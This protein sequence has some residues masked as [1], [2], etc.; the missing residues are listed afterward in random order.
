VE[1]E[2]FNSMMGVQKENTADV[3]G[4]QNIGYQ[5]TGDWMDYIVTLPNT[6][7]YTVNFRVATMNTGPQFQLRKP[8]GTVLATINVPNTGGWQNWQTVSAQVALTQGTQHLQIFTSN[9]A[10]GWNINWME[11]I[12]GSGTPANQPPTASAGTAQTIT[13]PV[14]TVQLTG[15]GS[16]AEGLVTFSW[17][18]VS[19][20]STAT[21]G[22]AT[23]ASTQVSALVAGSYVFR[24]TVTDNAGLTAQS[25]VT[26]TV[27]AAPN[28]GSSLKIEAEN[29]SAMFGVQKE[30]TSDAGGGQNVGGQDPGDWMDY[31]VNIPAAGAYTMHFRIATMVAGAQFQV[32]RSDGSILTTVNVPSTGAYQ[33]WQTITA[34]VSL[35]A[36]IQTVRIQ[37]IAS[38]GGWNMN[39]LEFVPG[40]SA[41]QPPSAN[42]GTDKSITLPVNSTSL[43][44]TAA[45]ADGTVAG[46]AWSQVSGPSTATISAP[47]ALNTQVSSLVAGTYIFRFT[48][49]DNAGAST[50]DDVQ[51]SVNPGSTPT[52]SVKIEAENYS[53]MSGIQKEAT[54][55]AGGGQN[56]GGQD[57]G[58]WMEYGVNLTTAG[59][60]TVNFR[61]ATMVSGAQFQ[62]KN[63]GG[64]ILAT[65]NVPSTGAYQSWQTI[66]TTVT[67]PSGPQTLRIQTVTSPGGW[68]LNWWEILAGGAPAPANTP[69]AVNAG[70]DRSITLP[71]NSISLTGTASDADGTIASY[72]WTQVSGP[73]TAS[74]SSPSAITTNVGSLLQGTYTFRFRATDN[75]GASSTDDVIVTVNPALPPASPNTLHIE[76]ENYSAMSGIQKENTSDI[77][78]GQNVGY[79]DVGDWMDYSVTIANPGTYTV[80]FRVA[81]MVSGAR[82][83]VRRTNGTILRTMD[84]PATGSYQTWQTITTTLTLPA[85][86]QTLRIQ[87]TLSPGGWNFNWWEIAGT[88]VTIAGQAAFIPEENLSGPVIAQ[89]GLQVYPNPVR[90]LAQLVVDNGSE[91]TVQVQVVNTAGMVVKAFRFA[92]TDKNAMKFDLPLGSLQKGAYIIQVSSEGWRDSRRVIRN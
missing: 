84:V 4:G 7:T 26:I 3:G 63:S 56:V 40:G 75:Q 22:S 47:S 79:Q 44:G 80:R 39:W 65:I 81:T 67:L 15:T 76:A 68:N 55:D 59:T 50:T 37:T 16:D 42:A 30:N 90:D 13:L 21:I 49:T 5:E 1:A 28:P 36:G 32:K 43:T 85:G 46:T 64:T 83:Q 2:N 66:S 33:S 41:N 72:S 86:T 25:E 17:T 91:G 58:D 19:G 6:G 89:N 82:F 35:P 74:I 31:A 23:S 57:P 48:V 78:G 12:S 45:D 61:I 29:Y 8:D 88:G 69:P 73:T 24:L 34:A 27:N 70:T 18:Q 53:T 92:K 9:A 77:G 87:T 20:P 51:V 52:N 54:Q 60:Y 11:F 62:L 38:P 14:S 71:V 10:G